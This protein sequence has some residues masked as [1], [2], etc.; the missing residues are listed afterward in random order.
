MEILTYIAA[1][2]M[3]P[4]WLAM[5]ALGVFMGI[6]IG[7]IPGLSATMAVSLLVSFTYGWNT[8]TALALMVGIYCGV[9]YGG[10]RSAIL[11]N[12]PGAPAAVATA[13]DGYPL[14]KKG[15][16]G[17][18]IGITT[19]ASVI[20]G[21]VGVLF[22]AVFAPLVSSFAIKFSPRDYLLLAFMGLM[23]VGS[24]GGRSIS[25]G[26]LSAV[27]GVSLGMVG[28]DAMTATPRF[29]FG[30]VYLMSGINYVVAMIGLFGVSEVLTQLLDKDGKVIRQKLDRI[31]P[32]FRDVAKH[33]PLT[34]R[35]SVIGTVIGALPGAGGDLAALI[36]YDQAKRTVKNPEVPFGQ[37]A[38]EG[39]IAPESANNACIGGAFIPMLTL[40]IPG[41]SVTAILIGALTIHG[42]Q[43]GPTM[44]SGTPDLFYY[45]IGALLLA[46]V[47]LLIF[48][49]TG[50]KIF[51][52]I[53]E[54]PKGILLPSI[55]IL[56]VIGVYSINNS[57][58]DIF[59][60]VGFGVLGYFMKRYEYPVAPAVLGIILASLIEKNFRRAVIMDG[61]IFH[62][63]LSMVTHP[64]SLVLI[65]I[66]VFMLVSQQRK[67]K[68]F[69]KDIED[70]N[71][72]EAEVNTGEPEDTE[73]PFAEAK[74]VFWEADVPGE[75]SEETESLKSASGR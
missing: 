71:V 49:L 12:I 34:I 21:F 26:M 22:L 2:L 73:A 10:S 27:L 47:F 30:N 65:L 6:Y 32:D 25:K 55:I 39:L 24:L 43:P 17:K 64:I 23:M 29:T 33:L 69:T 75:Q 37:G 41:D 70:K 67:V 50:V 53:V 18:A 15:L 61:D 3:N 13:L 28:L 35:S 19:V 36:T 52:K 20:G 51:T 66:I 45:I 9:V 56:S 40:G 54:I 8:N 16:A 57:L 14:A 48:G 58:Y 59:W 7:A 46:N 31:V 60:M 4:F 11:L 63:L 74:G 72:Y 5:V 38:M 68:N 62:M 1:P 42:L 44:M